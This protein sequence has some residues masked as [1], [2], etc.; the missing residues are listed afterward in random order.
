[1]LASFSLLFTHYSDRSKVLSPAEK[2]QV[3]KGLE[4][5]ATTGRDG[6]VTPWSDVTSRLG[7]D[8]HE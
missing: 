3:A 5:N 1:M 8:D 6:R 4:T 7:G 2:Q